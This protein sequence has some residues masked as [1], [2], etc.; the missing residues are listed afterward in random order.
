MYLS[1]CPISWKKG[2]ARILSLAV[3]PSLQGQ[4]IGSQLLKEGL[5]YLFAGGIPL[6]KLEVRPDNLAARRLYACQGLKEC[7]TFT[8]LQEEW[9]ILEKNSEN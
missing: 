8:D 3:L 1:P 5:A 6:V 2:Q 7:G 4:G 9:L